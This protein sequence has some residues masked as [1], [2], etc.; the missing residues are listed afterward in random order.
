[1]NNSH[2][3]VACAAGEAAARVRARKVRVPG[4]R[5]GAGRDVGDSRRRGAGL[6]ARHPAGGLVGWVPVQPTDD[7]EQP[8]RLAKPPRR[9]RR[10]CRPAPAPT[11]TQARQ[12]R[13]AQS[14]DLAAR[15]AGVSREVSERR[16][17][18]VCYVFSCR[19]R[20]WDKLF[21]RTGTAFRDPAN[22]DPL[23]AARPRGGGCHRAS[24]A[25]G[26][27]RIHPQ[28]I[29]ETT[30]VDEDRSQPSGSRLIS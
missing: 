3:G 22:A 7:M 8:D 15:T 21:I 28:T 29:C 23:P 4:A 17:D 2:T 14:Q 16:C 30:P 27:G 9:D 19:R 26:T 13:S 20:R 11:P 12:R 10:A 1:M 5:T 24:S 6:G 25:R 18:T